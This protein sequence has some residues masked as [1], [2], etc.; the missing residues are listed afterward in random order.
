LVVEEPSL[1][2]AQQKHCQNLNVFLGADNAQ[3][4]KTTFNLADSFFHQLALTCNFATLTAQQ[5]TQPKQNLSNEHETIVEF[6]IAILLEV[7]NN[8]E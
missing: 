1:P 8:F 4:I 3:N 6:E 7:L 2:L 5:D